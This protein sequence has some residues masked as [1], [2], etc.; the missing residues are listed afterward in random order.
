M[1]RLFISYRNAD[2][3]KDAHRLC[4]DLC[5]C[6][7]EETVFFDKQDLRAGTAWRD[8]ITAA[9]DSRP[10][11]LLL[12]SP[13]WLGE[14]GPGGER[15]IDQADDPVRNE[16]LFTRQVGATIVPLLSDGADMPSAA[17]LPEPLR[18]LTETHALR[19]RTD[20][21]AQDLERLLQQL[22]PLGLVRESSSRSGRD[23]RRVWTIGALLALAL[24]AAGLW[25]T[26][27][28]TADPAGDLAHAFAGVWWW[29]PPGAAPVRL[30]LTRQGDELALSTAP[31]PVAD[32]PAWRTYAER[33]LGQGLR[34]SEVRWIG[35]GRQESAD[36]NFV[37]EAFGAAGEGMLDTGRL[38]LKASDDGQ[39]LHGSLWSNGEQ[40]AETWHLRRQ[41]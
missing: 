39:S 26:D 32:H 4:D 19:L 25:I 16:L 11:V 15:R 7:G 23:A 36:L 10:L 14:T 37:V 18:F 41:P 28:G 2:G 31:F 40:A 21:W 30:E 1:H 27:R 8:A 29:A 24:A 20:D 3:K 13:G 12:M 34:L 22:V 5:R 38:T 35:K 33:L 9:L 6:F 17:Q